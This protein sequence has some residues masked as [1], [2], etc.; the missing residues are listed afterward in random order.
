MQVESLRT[1]SFGRNGG[2]PLDLEW[3]EECQANKTAIE[4]RCSTLLGRR[5]VK[6]QHQLAWLCCAISCMDLTSLNGDDTDGTVRRL[7]SKAKNP[8]REDLLSLLGFQPGELKVGAVC[9]YHPFVKVAVEA[10]GG[11]DIPVAA[12]STAFPHGLAPFETRLREIE[13]SVADGASEIDVVITRSHALTSNWKALFEEVFAF[14]QACGNAH[15]K[16]ILATGE[17]A[18]LRNVARASMVSMMAGAD[19]IKTSTGKEPTNATLPFGLVMA[20]CIRE[21]QDRT[22]FQVGLKPAGGIRT[23]KQSLDWLI[24]MKEELGNSWLSPDLFRIGASALL[25]DIE[26]QIEH[27]LTGK[28]SA[29]N[30]HPMA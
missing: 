4:R 18:T 13:L 8:V 10:L 16:V 11:S 1:P 28:Y 23:A 22:G 7:C 19:F 14:R 29:N 3:V 17:L 26:R 21:Y 30:R 20:R 12:V 2:I 15:L 6:K 5:T 9:V 25:T 27:G 24:L